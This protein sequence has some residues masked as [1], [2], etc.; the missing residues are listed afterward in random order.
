MRQNQSMTM[1]L[2]TRLAI[3]E[4]EVLRRIF[5]AL[6]VGGNWR[7]RFNHEMYELCEDMDGDAYKFIHKLHF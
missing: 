5:G 6:N 7:I 2:I 1:T 4:R 3:F